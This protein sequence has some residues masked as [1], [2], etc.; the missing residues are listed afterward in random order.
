MFSSCFGPS[1]KKKQYKLAPLKKKQL[2]QICLDVKSLIRTV[3]SLPPAVEGSDNV[4][5]SCGSFGSDLVG[6]E[7]LQQ[8]PA[9]RRKDGGVNK[10]QQLSA[11]VEKFKSYHGPKKGNTER[12]S[13]AKSSNT[14]DSD[15]IAT[16]SDTTSSTTTNKQSASINMCM[17]DTDLVHQWYHA[18]KLIGD[19]FTS[20]KNAN[21]LSAYMS[22]DSCLYCL[23]II[24][25]H[26]VLVAIQTSKSSTMNAFPLP[27]IKEA[28]LEHLQKIAELLD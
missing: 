2:E 28:I 5:I 21:I 25:Q 6:K 7:S 11:V 8:Q 15:R 18:S 16:V 1:S 10:A 17:P 27:A 12:K 20:S 23:F 24:E 22:G 3:L 9:D 13:T 4:G 26:Y 14:R 19:L